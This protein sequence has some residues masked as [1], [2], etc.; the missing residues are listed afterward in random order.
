MT[1][2][3]RK[4]IPG[5][6]VFDG[7][8]SALGYELNKLVSSLA[9]AE[10]RAAFIA[11][12]DAYVARFALTPEQR[13]ALKTRNF[14]RM[15]QLGANIYYLY[16]MTALPEM[17]MKMTELGALQAGMPHDDYLK[18]LYGRGNREWPG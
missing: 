10:N 2:T 13:E 12:E 3:D 8:Q 1:P 5:T 18:Q 11:D 17:R 16:K 6:Y 9:K 7:K 15:L 14:L 4:P